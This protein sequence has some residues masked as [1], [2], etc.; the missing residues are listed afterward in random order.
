MTVIFVP[1][2][3]KSC[4]GKRLASICSVSV[5]DGPSGISGIFLAHLPDFTK[6][7]IWFKKGKTENLVEGI[8]KFI[9]EL[10]VVAAVI[11]SLI[12]VKGESETK[13]Q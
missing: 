13:Q 7:M 5:E 11:F 3:N 9:K 4:I 6:V 1:C 12:D 8:E 2:M 10:D